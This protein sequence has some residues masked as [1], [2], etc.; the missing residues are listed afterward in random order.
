ML[1]THQLSLFHLEAFPRTG[2][3]ADCW[4]SAYPGPPLM[5]IRQQTI[6]MSRKE[7]KDHS[8]ARFF[9]GRLTWVCCSCQC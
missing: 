2:W 9:L 6:L 7:E 4:Q 3:T 8:R 1:G 5:A